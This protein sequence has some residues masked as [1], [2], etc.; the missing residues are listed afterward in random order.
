MYQGVS[1]R[2]KV[3]NERK[4]PGSPPLPG[5]PCLLVRHVRAPQAGPKETPTPPWSRPAGGRRTSYPCLRVEQD[6]GRG[7]GDRAS[8]HR[9][10][11]PCEGDSA[12]S[13]S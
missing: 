2:V 9:S 8:I 1:A 4:Q 7:T 10:R 13:S 11:G 3:S 5:P 12:A 6:G